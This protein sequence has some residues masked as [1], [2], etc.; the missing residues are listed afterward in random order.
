MNEKDYIDANNVLRDKLTAE[1]EAYYDVIL[2]HVRSYLRKDTSVAEDALLQV[3]QDLLDAQAAGI[4]AENYFGNDAKAVAD[5]IVA[6]LPNMSLLAFVKEWWRLPFAFAQWPLLI[7]VLKA[8]YDK[9]IVGHATIDLLQ[10]VNIL[11]IGLVYGLL[12]TEAIL[13]LVIRDVNKWLAG[14]VVGILFAG[15]VG[16]FWFFGFHSPWHWYI[17]F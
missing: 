1:N 6:G 16:A 4:T 14:A 15:A 9:L 7:I 8:I 17:N 11:G 12:L 10:Y 2:V 3:L 13:V 5:E